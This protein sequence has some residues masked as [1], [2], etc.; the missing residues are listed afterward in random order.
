MTIL[1]SS[2]LSHME[3]D[4]YL[5][6]SFPVKKLWATVGNCRHQKMNFSMS[7]CRGAVWSKHIA[8]GFFISICVLYFL[9]M[10]HHCAS[11][12]K[13]RFIFGCLQW[14]TV[15][16]LLY[17]FEGQFGRPH[18][19][20]LVK[21]IQEMKSHEYLPFLSLSFITYARV[22]LQKLPVTTATAVDPSLRG[23]QT[24][25]LTS[26]VVYTTQRELTCMEKV[27]R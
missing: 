8:Y 14:L 26:S 24:Q 16:S 18:F 7:V 9:F 2:T 4:Q 19:P 22:V 11:K 23:Q 20:N 25:V 10:H 5:F 3:I 21:W 27:G 15:V 6:K 13:I 1:P 12:Q 17:D